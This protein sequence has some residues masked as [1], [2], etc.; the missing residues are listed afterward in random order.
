MAIMEEQYK[1]TQFFFGIK[2]VFYMIFIGFP[3]SMYFVSFTDFANPRGDNYMYSA[4]IA[5]VFFVIY[6][7]F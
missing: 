4:A 2:F 6:E 5:Q 7:F 1:K 3:M